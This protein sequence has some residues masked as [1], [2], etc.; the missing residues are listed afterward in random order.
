MTTMTA[1]TVAAAGV[2]FGM[3]MTMMTALHIGIEAECAV[4]KFIHSSIRTAADTAEQ[5]D[6][7]LCQCILCTAAYSAA[8]KSIYPKYSKHP[9]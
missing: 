6:A 9:R 4:Q 3:F 5:I 2:T 7:C 1:A 8:N